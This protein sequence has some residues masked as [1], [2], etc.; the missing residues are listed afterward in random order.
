M[1]RPATPGPES[2]KRL[3]HRPE[4][5]PLDDL[6]VP[7]LE[8]VG[9]V[10]LHSYSGL[11]GDA[12]L[13]HIDDDVVARVDESLRLDAVVLPAGVPV[14]HVVEQL[15]P[16]FVAGLDAGLLGPWIDL[17]LLAR[18]GVPALEVGSR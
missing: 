12:Y 9:K 17:D 4:H 11:L 10:R 18:D 1:R 8:R 13:P 16:A 7:H 5:S 2:L 14:D 6:A 15:V 3:V